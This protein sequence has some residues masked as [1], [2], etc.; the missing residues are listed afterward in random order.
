MNKWN[1]SE[2]ISEIETPILFVV[3][4]NNVVPNSHSYKLKKLAKKSK[5]TEIYKMDDEHNYK[6]FISKL[7]SFV[8]ES[9]LK[10]ELDDFDDWNGGSKW[11]AG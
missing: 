8:K 11:K 6:G 10:Y 4:K 5:F 3:T 2:L 1:S 7:K 9:V